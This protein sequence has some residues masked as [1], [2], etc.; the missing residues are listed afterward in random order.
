MNTKTCKLCGIEKELSSF[1]SNRRAPDGLFAICRTCHRIRDAE[2][3]KNNPERAIEIQKKY[4]HNNK[5]V[6]EQKRRKKIDENFIAY[7]RRRKELELS[8]KS[9]RYGTLIDDLLTAQDGKCSICKNDFMDKVYD[10]DHDHQTMLI[11]GLLCRKCNSGLHYFEDQV[12]IEK[13]KS[14]LEQ[15]PASKFP[16]RKY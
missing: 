10:I 14:Y 11:R 12:F 1:Y 9:A 4:H 13:A 7:S 3:K 8:K 5:I 16:P 6:L 15:T 2:W